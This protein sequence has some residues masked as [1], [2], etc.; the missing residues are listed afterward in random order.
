MTAAAVTG[1]D[2]TEVAAAADEV[3]VAVVVG[4]VFGLGWLGTCD[5]DDNGNGDADA[6]GDV[7]GD[8]DGNGDD[9]AADTGVLIATGMG[10]ATVTG[11]PTVKDD[12]AVVM[13]AL[14]A[15][16]ESSED[17]SVSSADVGLLRKPAMLR[18]N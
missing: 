17:S 14:E 3:T 7:D 5:G 9:G 12:A 4:T 1:G 10:E 2:D 13:G 15:D 8:G 6:D 18:R 11:G 16:C